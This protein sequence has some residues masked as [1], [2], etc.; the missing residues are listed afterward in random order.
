MPKGRRILMVS[1]LFYPEESATAHILTKIAGELA[2]EFELLILT[3]PASYEGR[4]QHNA[5]KPPV[6]ESSIVRT[7]AP[8]LSKNKLAGRLVR[9]LALTIG[10]GWK[11][12]LISRRTDIVF[13]VTNPAP[14]L[15][16]LAMIRKIRR[17]E[18]VLLVHDVF[19]ENAVAAGI[20]RPDHFLYPL[21]RRVFDW[22]YGSAD[23]VITIGRDMSEVIA[24]K[25][26]ASADKIT[27]IENWADHP[28]VERISRNQSMIPSMGLS[29]R[30]VV[31]YAG[32]IGRAQGLL[33]FVNLVSSARNDNVRY[34]FRGSGALTL[35]LREATQGQQ[36]FIL[37]GSYPRAEQSR[38]LGACD[39]ALV[40]LGPDMYGLGVPSK[41]YNIMAS[42]KPV[43]F[44]GPKDSEIYRLVKSHDIGWAFDWNETDQLIELINQW[45][46][47]DLHAIQERGENARRIAE[48][49]YSE[50]VQLAK[51][52]TFF[53]RMRPSAT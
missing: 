46:I 49:S 52:T 13:A 18:L 15:V 10:L 8:K 2:Q 43:L 40:I 26:P 42:G 21:I 12:L 24:R 5:S 36:S 16:A 3:G 11:T 6:E 7:W 53:Q 48:T 35:A 19:P 51:F 50:A 25:I 22:A 9:F 29:N 23:A 4:A 14:L 33:E 41:T 1:E 32:N 28:L 20:I 17:S 31:Q 34:V 39:I 30:I 38:V 37:E 27:L 44:L 45:S 47:H